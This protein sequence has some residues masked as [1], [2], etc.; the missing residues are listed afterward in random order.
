MAFRTKIW[1]W[2]LLSPVL[3]VKAQERADTAF[4]KTIFWSVSGNG[5]PRTSYLFGTAHPIFRDNILLADTVLT[6][7]L[8][9]SAVYFERVPQAG[10]DSLY[11]EQCRMDRPKL[12][13]LLGTA[14]Y[15]LL[16][17]FLTEHQDSVLA[18]PLFLH[19][20]PQYYITRLVK[21]AYG[22]DLTTMDAFLASIAIGND[23]SVY[24]LD[25]PALQE[26][27]VN[28][29]SL[30][31]QADN[32]YY[33]LADF[34]KRMKEYAYFIRRMTAKYHEGDI[35]YLFTRT[36]YVRYTNRY[37]GF[38]YQLRQPSGEE[39]LDK[40]NM[41]WLPVIEKACQHGNCFFAFG[42]AHL[43]GH[44]GIINLLRK[45]GYTVTP[46]MLLREKL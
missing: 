46:V 8:H 18:D 32:L 9:S 21:T 27:L 17:K 40:R 35:G 29:V 1:W 34:E 16:V 13:P 24:A 7:L 11:R 6:T 22:D 36:N 31:Q 43:A 44:H 12:R 4:E 2:L 5:L 26:E 39:L 37:T 45:K 38:S 14:C 10:D 15:D 30:Q 19:L 20:S 28:R 42:A 3:P 25:S 41:E 33:I 23:Q